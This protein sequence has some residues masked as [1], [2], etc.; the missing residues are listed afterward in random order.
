MTRTVVVGY[1]S[2]KMMGRWHDKGESSVE[3]VD[4]VV[5]LGS[6]TE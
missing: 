3:I 4:L 5:G 6:S 1:V 2:D